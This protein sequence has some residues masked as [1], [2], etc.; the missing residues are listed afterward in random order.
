MSSSCPAWSA[1]FAALCQFCR[2][3]E[4]MRGSWG[5]VLS[6]AATGVRGRGVVSERYCAS[7]TAWCSFLL[8]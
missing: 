5:V 8:S 4:V 6:E 2:A 3:S 7:F 1:I